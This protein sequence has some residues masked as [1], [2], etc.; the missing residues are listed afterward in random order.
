[1]SAADRSDQALLPVLDT[2]DSEALTEFKNH[3]IFIRPPEGGMTACRS[4]PEPVQL[5]TPLKRPSLH[6]RQSG[7]RGTTSSMAHQGDSTMARVNP[8]HSTNIS[9]PHVHHDDSNCPVG[10]QIP[11]H[12]RAPGT[13]G[14]RRCQRCQ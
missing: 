3:L 7:R 4:C 6:T 8:Y 10:T 12:N 1:M 9:D 5:A 14:Y 11:P 13:N 2:M